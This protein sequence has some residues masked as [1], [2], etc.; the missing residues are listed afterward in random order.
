MKLHSLAAVALA[1]LLVTAGTAAATSGIAT[2]T[3]TQASDHAEAGAADTH[4]AAPDSTAA[5]GHADTNATAPEERTS[6][7]ASALP[8]QVPD[9]VSQVRALIR[10]FRDGSLDGPLGEA[11]SAVTSAAEGP[12]AAA[13]PAA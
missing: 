13:A 11:I 12:T 6:G 8:D 7:F 3:P 4:P 1:A 2:Q 10:Q 9:H 5:P